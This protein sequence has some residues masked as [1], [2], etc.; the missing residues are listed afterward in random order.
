MFSRLHSAC[1][2]GIDAKAISVE[3]DI[4]HGLICWHIV[5][6]PDAAVK[7]S[8]QRIASAIKNS[9]IKFPDRK[10]TVNLSPADLKK[11]GSLF[12]LAITLALLDAATIIS[13]PSYIK[14][15]SIIIGEIA[16]DGTLL[17]SRDALPI[18]ADLCFLSKK[19]LI[20]PFDRAHE[21]AII[22]NITIIAPKT[23]QELITWFTQ[24]T[25]PLYAPQNIF[26]SYQQTSHLDMSDVI[27]NERAKRALQI[28]AA[29]GHGALLIGSPGSGKTMLAERI[30]TIMPP[31]SK[32]EQIEMTKIHALSNHNER[33]LITVR[34]FIAPH[35]TVSQAGLVGG[36]SIPRP[37]AITL[38]HRGVLFLDELLE[39]KRTVIEVLR[40]PLESK[41]IT[42]SRAQAE[43]TFPA[44]FLL[45]AATN[46]CPCG[47][48]GDVRIDCT[49]SS[50]NIRNYMKKLSGPFLDR[51]DLHIPV[52]G[53]SIINTKENNEITSKDLYKGVLIAREK[54][55]K[56]FEGKN[57]LNGIAQ[58][59]LLKKTLLIDSSAQKLLED[60]YEKDIL[61]MRGYYKVIAIAQTIADIENKEFI[62]EKH[63]IEAS[64][65]RIVDQ[66]D[67]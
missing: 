49:C 31:P 8:K 51:I 39:F 41:K 58:S 10:V 64:S 18:A 45:I 15:D 35:H 38:A 20:V 12:D 65:Y 43:Y 28:A 16:L 52:Y 67:I 48:Y 57:V 47:H 63:I 26:S 2:C 46:P 7:E 60:I 44:D 30:V 62:E 11:E 27:G 66:I 56:R 61:T 34:P 4:S 42:V 1:I 19:Y 59:M 33:G 5:G 17:G 29:G 54:Q 9:G 23:L 32:E 14:N 55:K 25:I 40:Q 3:V 53:T 24:E 21:V 6:L 13:I 50:N 37:G 36:G 22:D